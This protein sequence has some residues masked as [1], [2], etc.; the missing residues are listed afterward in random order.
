MELWNS[1][2]ICFNFF[3]G[4]Q[5]ARVKGRLESFKCASRQVL[6]DNSSPRPRMNNSPSLRGWRRRDVCF[7]SFS[8]FSRA[9][10]EAN[11]STLLNPTD[12]SMGRVPGHIQMCGWSTHIVEGV[13]GKAFLLLFLCLVRAGPVRRERRG[14]RFFKVRRRDR[15]FGRVD[16]PHIVRLF[17]L[18]LSRFPSPLCKAFP[19]RRAHPWQGFQFTLAVKR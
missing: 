5:S 19:R 13:G 17:R 2:T 1:T 18:L 15:T 14:T 6:H 10:R 12:P 7:F 11:F 8:F 9:R 3:F 16:P 4:R